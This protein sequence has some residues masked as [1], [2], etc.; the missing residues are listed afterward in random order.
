MGETLV[1][2]HPVL[3]LIRMSETLVALSPCFSVN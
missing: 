2:L 1:A 3:V